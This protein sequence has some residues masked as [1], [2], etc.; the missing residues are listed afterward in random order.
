MKNLKKTLC[1]LLCLIMVVGLVPMTAFAAGTCP[2]TSVDWHV[3]AGGYEH[4]KSCTAPDC[5][6]RN[7]SITERGRHTDVNADRKCDD[8]SAELIKVTFDYENPAKENIIV[9]FAKNSPQSTMMPP[10]P[11]MMKKPA[12]PSRAG[13]WTALPMTSMPQSPATSL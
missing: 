7:G 5:D 4:W 13:L 8:C 11:L 12:T 6:D 2:H 9:L 3:S 10:L 1:L